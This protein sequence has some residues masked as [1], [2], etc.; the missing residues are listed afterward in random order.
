MEAHS[1]S[2]G[3]SQKALAPVEALDA[4]WGQGPQAMWMWRAQDPAGCKKMYFNSEM[5]A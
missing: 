2:A 5:F 3:Q 4:Q 1:T